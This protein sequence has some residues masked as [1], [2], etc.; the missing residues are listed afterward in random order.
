MA[1]LAIWRCRPGDARRLLVLSLDRLVHLFAVDGDAGRS[2]DAE[3]HLVASDV[4][5]G[6]L[7]L[8]ADHDRLIALP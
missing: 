3:A 1:W 8:V 4:D 7:D 5:D 2:V 6:D